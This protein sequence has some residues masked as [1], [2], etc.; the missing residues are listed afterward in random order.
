MTAAPPALTIRRAAVSRASQVAEAAQ[1]AF[2]SV[3]SDH[4]LVARFSDGRWQEAAIREYGTLPLAP[5]ISSL[6]YGLSVFEGLKAHRTI[7]GGVALFRPDANAARL[8]RSAARLAMPAVPQDLFLH[9]LRELVNLDR[10]W[11]PAPDRGALYVRPCLF[12]IDPSVRVKAPDECLFVI[13][14]FPFTHYYTGSVDLLV[15]EHY[16]RAFPGGTGDVKPAGNYAPT[17]VAERGAREAGMHSVL[18][19][20]GLERSYIEECAVMNV[21]FVIGDTVITPPLG[22]TILP[23]VT[24]DSA[25]TVLRDLGVSAV[26][27]PI[28]LKEVF[29]AAADGSLRECFGTGTAATL[30]HVRRIRHGDREIGLPPASEDSIGSVLRRQLVGIATGQIPDK[31]GWLDVL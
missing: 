27:R 7:S 28:A 22:G 17:L 23:G 13:F 16:V 19:L 29:A 8:N 10:D 14:T 11:V 3:F 24:R 2:S 18:W 26:E 9:G 25:L 1:I 12:S 4:M 15:S 6:Q 31:H 21:F 5:N 20:D 30:S